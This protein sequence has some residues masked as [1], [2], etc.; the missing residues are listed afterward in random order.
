MASPCPGIE[1]HPDTAV[2]GGLFDEA[3][4]AT[5]TD[6]ASNEDCDMIASYFFEASDANTNISES[7][8][9]SSNLD[10]IV[11]SIWKPDQEQGL[12]LMFK[13]AFNWLKSFGFNVDTSAL[14]EYLPSNESI[15]L[16]TELSTGLIL[17]LALV[18]IIRGL[19]RTGFF[20]FSQKPQ[21][22]DDGF[23][24]ENGNALSFEPVDGLP[25]REQLGALLQRSI[26]LLRKH[27]AVPVSHSYTNHELIKYL[28]TSKSALATLLFRQVNITE[29]V[30]YGT[31]SVTQEVVSESQQIYEDIGSISHE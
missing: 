26:S 9:L 5:D 29:P 8:L 15:R 14:Q 23:K 12:A 22:E 18:F 4:I 30:I 6:F 24:P 7:P 27:K 28:D 19:Y 20:K 10:V 2:Q 21:S 13:A 31:Q 3:L 1:I 11:D 25:L 16:F 17:L